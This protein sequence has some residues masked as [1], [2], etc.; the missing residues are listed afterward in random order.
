MK[1]FNHKAI[2]NIIFYH[3]AREWNTKYQLKDKIW[4][5]SPFMKYQIETMRRL[6]LRYQ[7][8]IESIET[9]LKFKLS[10]NKTCAWQYR[11]IGST[12]KTHICMR[13]EY[14]LKLILFEM[15]AY[16]HTN[17]W[18]YR[19]CQYWYQLKEIQWYRLK[20]Q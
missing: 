7:L 8:K 5:F 19:K 6:E 2:E 20:Q 14:Q 11:T 16:I 17:I 4:V 1:I 9:K 18:V 10:I 15:N 3:K 12:Y 13:N